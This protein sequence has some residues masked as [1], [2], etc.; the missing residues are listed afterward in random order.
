MTNKKVGKG[1]DN[2]KNKQLQLQI[3][4]FFAALR[5][6]TFEDICGGEVLRF[7]VEEGGEVSVVGF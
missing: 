5:M 7:W 2:C 3:Q 1:K 4:G 6:T